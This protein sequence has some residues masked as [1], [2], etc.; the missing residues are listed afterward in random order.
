MMYYS[1][2]V[3]L[4]VVQIFIKDVY[5]YICEMVSWVMSFLWKVYFKKKNLLLISK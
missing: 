2:V 4:S 3:N 5:I 1:I